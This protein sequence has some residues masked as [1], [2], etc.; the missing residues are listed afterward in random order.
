MVTVK[1]RDQVRRYMAQTPEALAARILP[2]AARA[3]GNVVADE[4]RRRA[5]A[6]VVSENITVSVKSKDGRVVVRVGV[7]EG[8]P[9]SLGTW[10]E[11]GTH[12]HFISVDPALAQGRTAA[13]INKL[14]TAAAKDGGAG[15]G[16][17]LVINGKPVGKTV[18]HPGAGRRPFL[19]DSLDTKEREAFAA[20]QEY[21]NTRV[22]RLR[23]T[24]VA[25]GEGPDQ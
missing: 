19:R 18:F 16:V 4:A 24:G 17:T 7:A 22:A 10:L 6:D 1:G 21:I 12:A 13:R 14:D 11:Y 9:R 15:P 23:R 3:A 20:A 8:W 25:D 2:G 5:V